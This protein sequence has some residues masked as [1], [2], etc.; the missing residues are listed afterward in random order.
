MP[1]RI[2]DALREHAVPVETLDPAPEPV[3]RLEDGYPAEVANAV[4]ALVGLEE[5]TGGEPAVVGLGETTHGTRECFRLKT[6]LIQLLVARGLRTVAFE[7]DVTATLALDA[8][9]RRGEGDPVTAV[10]GLERWMW[11][12]ESVRDLLCWLRS[13]NRGRPPDDQV[14]VRGVDLG[15]P[16]APASPLRSYFEAV[17]PGYAE[18]SDALAGLEAIADGP[19]PDDPDER[20]RV[21]DAVEAMADTL[22][23]R[24]AAGQSTYVDAAGRR[25]LEHARHLCRVVERTCDWHRVRHEKPGPHEAGMAQR[26]RHMASN[27]EWCADHDPG[28]GVAVWAH[29][30]HIERGNFDDGRIWSDATGMGEALAGAFGGRYTPVG[31][32]AGAGNFRAVGAGDTDGQGPREFSFGPQPGGTARFA[33]VGDAPW[34]LDLGAAAGD[35]RLREWVDRPQQMR[36]V[37]TVYDPDAPAKHTLQTPLTAFDGLV[38]VA[39]ST[40]SRPVAE[41]NR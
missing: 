36:C 13:F 17:D 15:H 3:D 41:S 24:L 7:A 2:T 20:E 35:P 22:D 30:I 14:R 34:I 23:S 18:Q 12:V 19:V 37:G 10:A 21:L 26:D 33:Q 27:V 5:S 40:P 9:V 25:R 1:D 28:R 16:A 8:Y 29:N 11:R 39:E 38:F 4:S 32:D 31:F 6:G